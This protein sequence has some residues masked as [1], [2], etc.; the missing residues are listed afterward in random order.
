MA[1]VKVWKE[2]ETTEE[3]Y[4]E[5]YADAYPKEEFTCVSN[6]VGSLDGIIDFAE[7]GSDS[8]DIAL[9]STIDWDLL[10]YGWSM[11]DAILMNVDF[12]P[13]GGQYRTGVLTF[14]QWNRFFSYPLHVFFTGAGKTVL[15]VGNLEREEVA[16]VVFTT[17][18]GYKVIASHYSRNGEISEEEAIQNLLS[19][20]T[21]IKVLEDYTPE[22]APSIDPRKAVEILKDEFNIKRL[23]VTSGG[24][25]I[26]SFIYHKLIH[27]VR[28]TLAAHLVG[29]LNT[30]NQTRSS[31]FPIS[32]SSETPNRF[33]YTPGTTP[34]LSFDRLRLVGN[35]HIF[36]RSNIT[37]RH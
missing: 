4:A 16:C 28:Y 35:T 33:T 3:D 34:L 5:F 17:A 1:N 37:Y 12:P 8:K 25:T 15:G 22:G 26:S 36:F 31:I 19:K 23:E 6:T 20:H 18:K 32:M 24:K 30:N 21:I 13:I 2:G 9:S 10:N 14:P 29:N 27:E 11:A 7:K